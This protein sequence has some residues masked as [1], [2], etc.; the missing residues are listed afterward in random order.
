MSNVSVLELLL[1]IALA[2]FAQ[3]AIVAATKFYRHWQAYKKLKANVKS[4]GDGLLDVT[5]PQQVKPGSWQGL[6]EL[7]VVRKIYENPCRSICSFYLA[8][9][10]GSPLPDFLPGQF[11]TFQ[12]DAKDLVTGEH[13]NVTRCYSLSDRSNTGYYRVSIKRE[14][15]PSSPP[16]LPPGQ[17]SNYFHDKVAENDILYAR[18]PGGNFF[19][20]ANNAPIV[21]IA[22]GVGLTPILSMLNTVLQEESL[23]EIWLFY[24]VRNSAEHVM[25]SHLED[26]ARKH[27]NFR[28]CTCYSRPLPGDVIGVDYWQQGRINI[29]LLRLTLSF[30]P[31]HFYICGPKPLLESLVPAIDKWGVPRQF[32]HYEAFGP[33]SIR[34][35]DEKPKSAAP[36]SS[37]KKNIFVTF[38]KSNKTIAWEDGEANI[39]EF[40]EKSGIMVDSGCRS[41]SCGTCQVKIAEGEVDYMQTPDIDP[42]PGHCLLCISRPKCN[43]TLLA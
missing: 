3:I 13:K 35:P 36:Q 20:Q 34:L 33:A 40:A 12:F 43:L 22:G 31:Y 8:P 30:R 11:L 25:K 38:A 19:L 6:R 9:V 1:F 37:A 2:I 26:L 16:N 14:P 29:S 39:L 10:S 5:T 7:R 23:R 24:G 4:F 41:G 17:I 21:L 32:V 15:A 27:R 28:L 42:E 18:A